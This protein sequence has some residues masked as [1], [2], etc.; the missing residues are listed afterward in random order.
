LEKTV[1][2][3]GRPAARMALL[4]ALWRELPCKTILKG[5][6]ESA[7]EQGLGHSERSKELRSWTV[8][9]RGVRRQGAEANQM[10]SERCIG[11]CARDIAV[12][13]TIFQVYR[14][15]YW[16]PP[17]ITPDRG[18]FLGNWCVDC[19]LRDYGRLV[20]NQVQPYECSLCGRGFKEHDQAIYATLGTRPVPL[21]Q[22]AG[23][24]LRAEIRGVH[25]IVGKECWTDDRFA[26]LYEIYLESCSTE[27]DRFLKRWKV[28]DPMHRRKVRHP[29]YGPG[30]VVD[31][32]GYGDDRRIS[33]SFPSRGI[34]K[35]IER[36]AF[37]WLVGPD[38]Y[39]K[40]D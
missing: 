11:N 35:F 2:S 38:S 25:L 32:E 15:G 6:P 19:F 37:D 16:P 40:R 31:V 24:T 3:S 33:V 20:R 21:V 34:K 27:L 8:R 12:G 17:Y 28:A 5:G 7:S 23:R 22:H 36:Y 18:K 9:A 10:Q 1:L 30:T 4:V 13:Q 26:K 39:G 14:G 29:D